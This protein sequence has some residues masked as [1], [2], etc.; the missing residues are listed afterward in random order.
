MV[1][2]PKRVNWKFRSQPKT[3]N[4]RD[5]NNAPK[6]VFAK[7]VVSVSRLS[8]LLPPMSQKL[9][10]HANTALSIHLIITHNVITEHLHRTPVI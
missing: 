8:F 6:V 3:K 5:S 10:E 9:L 2:L 4:V 7:K 1:N